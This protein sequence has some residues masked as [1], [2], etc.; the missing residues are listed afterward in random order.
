MELIEK[1][2]TKK[3]KK[4]NLNLNLK[5]IDK[6]LINSECVKLSK[7]KKVYKINS[8]FDDGFIKNCFNDISVNHLVWRVNMNI[9]E[10]VKTI[11][12]VSGG[13]ILL[14]KCVLNFKDFVIDKNVLKLS[15]LVDYNVNGVDYFYEFSLYFNVDSDCDFNLM[16]NSVKV[17]LLNGII[18]NL[19]VKEVT[20]NVK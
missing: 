8:F 5:S 6:K 4:V 18:S 1:Q 13:K 9:K 10:V 11:K 16:T 14:K 7:S 19:L 12:E 20:N 15:F 17:R 2:K 3:F